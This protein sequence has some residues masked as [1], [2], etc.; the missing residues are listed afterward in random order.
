M[1]SRW[2][3]PDSNHE[4]GYSSFLH[5]LS[6]CVCAWEKGWMVLSILLSLLFH[7]PAKRAK[8]FFFFLFAILNTYHHHKK[9]FLFFFS[10][11]RF[12]NQHLR[13]LVFMGLCCCLLVY[14][15]KH[16]LVAKSSFSGG[17]E[18]EADEISMKK[19]SYSQW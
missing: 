12:F 18:A 2:L 17:I 16:Y 1:V 19:V 5:A 15:V 3:L 13:S 4:G 8:L 6:V 7:C 14:D 11:L 10:F 9:S